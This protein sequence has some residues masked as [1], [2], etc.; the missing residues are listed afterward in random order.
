VT[1]SALSRAAESKRTA[2]Q[3]YRSAVLKAVTEHGVSATARAAG[4]SRQ[5]V[6]QLMARAGAEAPT[7]ARPK[8]E[9]AKLEKR[10]QRV[11][12]YH[13]KAYVLGEAASI[14][15]GRNMQAKKRAKRGLPPLPTVKSE[16][17]S[18]AESQVLALLREGLTVDA[19]RDSLTPQ[20][21]ARLEAAGSE[22]HDDIP[23]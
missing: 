2:E 6:R 19:G 3:E 13:A 9:A 18:L 15:R 17:F 4:I 12:T 11:V 21:L 10:Y 1:L 22:E 14:T 20:D 16:A 23:F 5:A 7:K 8:I